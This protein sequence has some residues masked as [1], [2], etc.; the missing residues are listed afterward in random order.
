MLVHTGSWS[1]IPFWRRKAVRLAHTL[2]WICTLR[3]TETSNLLEA[4]S[5]SSEGSQG[6]YFFLIHSEEFKCQG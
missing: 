2:S 1:T 6:S 3:H 5:Q 4:T